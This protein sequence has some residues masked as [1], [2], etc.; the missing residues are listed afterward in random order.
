[1]AAAIFKRFQPCQSV[2][3]TKCRHGSHTL[4][5]FLLLLLKLPDSK[6]TFQ[7]LLELFSEQDQWFELFNALTNLFL[8]NDCTSP[9]QRPFNE[10]TEAFIIVINPASLMSVPYA[11]APFQKRCSGQT[12]GT[13][14]TAL[15][16]GLLYSAASISRT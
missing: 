16:S 15:E 9:V 7:L 10:K 5:L 6:L 8:T 12:Q 13:R 4:L 11:T 14:C 3:F 1:M 2:F